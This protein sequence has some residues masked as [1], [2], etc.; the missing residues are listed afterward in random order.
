MSAPVPRHA[1][2]ED[3]LRAIL[4]E[5]YRLLLAI[6]ERKAAVGETAAEEVERDAGAELR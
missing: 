2:L 4:A 6:A 5:A 3:G 1:E